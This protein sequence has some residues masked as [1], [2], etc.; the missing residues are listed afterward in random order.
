M[1]HGLL[2]YR[3]GVFYQIPV[4]LFYNNHPHYQNQKNAQL[5]VN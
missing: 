2:I 5:Y 3:A 4:R 1:Q